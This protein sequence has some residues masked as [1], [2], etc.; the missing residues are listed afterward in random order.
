MDGLK[1]AFLNGDGSGVEELLA[2]RFCVVGLEQL[3][4]PLADAFVGGILKLDIE[5][6]VSL[7]I[8]SFVGPLPFAPNLPFRLAYE[9]VEV[10]SL[11]PGNYDGEE[12]PVLGVAGL[13]DR[14][15]VEE[16]VQFVLYRLDW[17]RVGFWPDFAWA[18]CHSA[19]MVTKT[20]VKI[21]REVMTWPWIVRS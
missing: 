6:D 21:K 10:T 17:H 2:D 13:P 19:I 9:E 8:E 20:V 18:N 3:D 5:L 1:G 4:N 16:G 15:I 11:C 14:L 12:L 7:N